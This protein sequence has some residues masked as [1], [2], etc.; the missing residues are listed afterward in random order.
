M[1]EDLLPFFVS[2]STHQKLMRGNYNCQEIAIDFCVSKPW[3]SCTS[4]SQDKSITMKFDDLFSRL[5][6]FYWN[7]WFKKFPLKIENKKG[8]EEKKH[9]CIF[10][11]KPW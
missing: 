5:K 1:F 2:V 8:N 10:L 9:Y 4:Y 3:N 6:Y 7:W 11:I